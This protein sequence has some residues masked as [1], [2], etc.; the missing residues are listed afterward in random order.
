M[1]G[2]IWGFDLSSRKLGFSRSENL[3]NS[4]FIGQILSVGSNKNLS[5]ISNTTQQWFSP[6]KNYSFF[7]D[8]ISSL[9]GFFC[10][11]L[12]L[13]S[14][15]VWKDNDNGQSFSQHF[16]KCETLKASSVLIVGTKSR[17]QELQSKETFILMWITLR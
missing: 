9:L 14:P 5:R 12:L 8:C 13:L 10:G 3:S 2:G 11:N 17:G 16:R 7:L 6:P 1:W 15:V 4:T